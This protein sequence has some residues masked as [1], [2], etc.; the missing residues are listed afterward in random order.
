MKWHTEQRKINDLIPF[1][2]NPRQLIEQQVIDLK[3][4]LV[5]FD[6]VEIP[7]I[8]TTNKILAGHQ[9]LKILQLLG[10]GDE[11]IDVRVPDRELSVGEE[12]EYLLR[13]NKNVG[14]W[15]WDALANFDEELLIESGFTQEE[16]L[17]NF[18]LSDAEAIEVEKERMKVITVE[19]PEAPRIFSRQSF[20]FDKLEDF[21]LVKDTFK[22][23]KDGRLDVQKLVDLLKTVQS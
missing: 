16:L 1:D 12:Q 13:S 17:K 3:K 6:L 2:G 22:S 5:K 11:L 20:Y 4:S 7:A 9:R 18:G 10:R 15:D 21:E 8:T 19:A 14:E 23:V